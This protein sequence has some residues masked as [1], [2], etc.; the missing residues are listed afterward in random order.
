MKTTFKIL[1]LAIALVFSVS[2]EAG[3]YVS[4]S[5]SAV[6]FSLKNAGFTV[7]GKFSDVKA[8]VTFDESNLSSSSFYGIVKASTVSTGNSLRDRH[9]RNKAA[10][11]NVAKFP[12]ITMKSTSIKK[13]SAGKYSVEWNLKMKGITKK[14]KTTVYSKKSSTGL[15]L[16]TNFN[17]NRNTWG[18]GGSS[19]TMGDIVTMKLST[20]VK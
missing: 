11:F 20:F 10:F 2:L 4:A 5:K 13:I 9:L 6:S 3:K 17:I 14:V 18:L 19:V 12:S 1:F 7:K 15:Y 16:S 8:K